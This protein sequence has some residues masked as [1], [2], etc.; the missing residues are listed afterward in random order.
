[1][2]HL[3]RGTC[4]DALRPQAL[5][6]HRTSPRRTVCDLEEPAARMDQC[7]A[8]CSTT[9]KVPANGAR[10]RDLPTLRGGR[11]NCGSPA[12]LFAAGSADKLNGSGPHSALGRA[13]S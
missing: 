8:L 10:V 12:Q 1:M 13:A 3:L 9:P 4:R 6:K 11:K 7:Q 2:R 5:E